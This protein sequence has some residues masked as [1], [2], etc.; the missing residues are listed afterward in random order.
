MVSN[1]QQTLIEA[2]DRLPKD[3]AGRPIATAIQIGDRVLHIDNSGWDNFRDA[4]LEDVKRIWVEQL[5][6]HPGALAALLL[7]KRWS[8]IRAPQSA[9]ATSDCPVRFIDDDDQGR[10]VIIIFP[11]S[12]TRLLFLDDKH[13][14][15]NGLVFLAPPQMLLEL[16]K[17][18]LEG[19]QRFLIAHAD[20]TSLLQQIGILR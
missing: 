15:P 2:F 7:R 20:P 4:S 14:D 9:F 3:E 18:T 6:K 1:L 10:G 12:P 19:A 8:I 17:Q 16:N 13:S 5:Q 11:L